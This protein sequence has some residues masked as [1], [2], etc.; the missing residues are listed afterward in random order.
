MKLNL[1]KVLFILIVIGLASFLTIE[2]LI[3]LEANRDPNIDKVDYVIVLGARLYRDTPSPA[4]LERLKVAN[5]YL[6]EH[7]D[8]E[9]IVSGGQGHDESIPEAEAMKRYLVNNGI[10]ENRIIM[11]DES[12]NTFE[13]LKYTRDIIRGLDEKEDY[14]VLIVTN[15]FHLFRAKFL[16]K[17]LGMVPYG[18]PARI[19][20]SVIVQSYIREYFAVI[21][22]FIFDR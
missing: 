9:V 2:G 1:F 4:L 15:K 20:P 19:P 11:E 17:R 22:S 13:N 3:F 18:L 6:K 12:T 14:R 5:E 8:V 10:E 7:K 21:K 16:A